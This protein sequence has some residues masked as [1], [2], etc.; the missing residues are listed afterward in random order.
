MKINL[1]YWLKHSN[2]NRRCRV[3]FGRI[4]QQHRDGKTI[5]KKPKKI[6]RT[7]ESAMEIFLSVLRHKGSSLFYDI[8]TQE[9][10]LKSEDSSIYVFLER[11][12]LKII[13]SIFGYDV[14]VSQQLEGFLL[15]KFIREMAIRRKT[16]KTEAL[17]KV[18]H[19]LDRVQNKINNGI[20]STHHGNHTNSNSTNNS[21]NKN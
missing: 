14:N 9:C 13:N 1:P 7:E 16:F 2:I 20:K 3:I 19:S 6:T 11:E 8:H 5:I 12:N 4:A 17:S 18:N 21:P 15:E 10:Y